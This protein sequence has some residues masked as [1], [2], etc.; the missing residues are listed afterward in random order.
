MWF[1]V[2]GILQRGKLLMMLGQCTD[3]VGDFQKVTEYV[4]D[5]SLPHLLRAHR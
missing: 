2:Q 3:A 1:S 4:F 5:F